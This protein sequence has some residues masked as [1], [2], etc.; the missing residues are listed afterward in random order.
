MALSTHGSKYFVGMG[1]TILFLTA[2]TLIC[3]FIRNEDASGHFGLG[4]IACSLYVC[5]ANY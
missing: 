2:A 5:L 3:G 4:A 1:C